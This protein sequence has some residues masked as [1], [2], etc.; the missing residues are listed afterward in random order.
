M[1]DAPLELTTEIVDDWL[2]VITA[3]GDWESPQREAC[4][5]IWNVVRDEKNRWFL[6]DLADVTF[7]GEEMCGTVWQVVKEAARRGGAV[8]VVY[9]DVSLKLVRLAFAGERIGLCDTIAAAKCLLEQVR[10]GRADVPRI[11]AS[12]NSS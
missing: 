12:P 2:V 11:G 8:A 10:Q 1:D 6:L 5:V 9:G 4:G 3:T 7:G